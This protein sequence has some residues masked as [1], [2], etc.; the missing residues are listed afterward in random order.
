MRILR[1]LLLALLVSLLVGL[2]VGTWIR[3]RLEQPVRY[4]GWTQ[5]LSAP[6]PLPGHVRQTRAAILEPCEHEQQIG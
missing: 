4:I 2:A 6:P 3:L 1:G 5:P